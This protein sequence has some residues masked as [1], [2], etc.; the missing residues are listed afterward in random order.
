MN[1]FAT[2]PLEAQ[3]MIQEKVEAIEEMVHNPS[4]TKCGPS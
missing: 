2:L 1:T 3:A 4:P